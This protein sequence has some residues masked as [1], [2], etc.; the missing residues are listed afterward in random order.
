[1]VFCAPKARAKPPIPSAAS[2]VVISTPI[3][4][5]IQIIPKA[6]IAI[7]AALFRNNTTETPETLPRELM[8]R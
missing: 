3:A 1:M 6:T 2:P 5:K 4:P 7:L 8:R